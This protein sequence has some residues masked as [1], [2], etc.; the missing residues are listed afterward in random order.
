M[1]HYSAPKAGRRGGVD[2]KETSVPKHIISKVI[3]PTAVSI[4][5][6]AVQEE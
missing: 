2:A 5:A 1:F 4:P 3:L 6:A